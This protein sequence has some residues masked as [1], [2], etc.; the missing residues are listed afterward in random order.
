MSGMDGIE[1]CR[2]FSSTAAPNEKRMISVKFK[3]SSRRPQQIR[4][5]HL[6]S[7]PKSS[8]GREIAGRAKLA[9]HCSE[10]M[11]LPAMAT[12]MEKL[13]STSKQDH[14]TAYSK[15]SG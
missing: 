13:K 6:E 1:M 11:S 3:N 15:L 12:A 4:F 8:N 10:L 9:M 14:A 5:R 7:K 2:T